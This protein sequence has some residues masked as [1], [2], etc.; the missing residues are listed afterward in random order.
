[1]DQEDSQLPEMPAQA[2]EGVSPEL[3]NAPRL[4]PDQAVLP[5]LDQVRPA[6]WIGTAQQL[7]WL[8]GLIKSVLI[9][10]LFDAVMTVVWVSDRDAREANP[11]LYDLPAEHPVFFVLFK[12]GMVSAGTFLLWRHR[13]RP[14]AVVSIFVAFLTY[15]FLLA[16][17]LLAL[18]SAVGHI[19]AAG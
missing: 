19:L 5:P 1:M 12:T 18:R 15:Y 7:R 14:L 4:L 6:S 17:H 9:L 8:E 3:L 16:W 10:N 13:D 11:L 2:V